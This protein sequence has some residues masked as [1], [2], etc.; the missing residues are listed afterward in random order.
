MVLAKD[1]SKSAVRSVAEDDVR[2][3]RKRHDERWG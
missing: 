1:T 2:K 3:I